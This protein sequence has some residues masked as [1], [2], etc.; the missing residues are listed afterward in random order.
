M[1]GGAGNDGEKAAAARQADVGQSTLRRWLR[2]DDN[3]Q[4]KLRQFREL[5]L[6]HAAL[7]LQQGVATAVCIMYDLIESGK[8]IDPGRVSLIRIAIEF[9]FRAAVYC[10]ILDR[11]KALEKAQ[12]QSQPPAPARLIRQP[13]NRSRARQQ[14]VSASSRSASVGRQALP[15]LG[16]KHFQCGRQALRKAPAAK[17]EFSETCSDL[18]TPRF[19]RNKGGAW[20]RRAAP[21]LRR[22]VRGSRFQWPPSGIRKCYRQTAFLTV[23]FGCQVVKN[24]G[25]PS[26][27][28]SSDPGSDIKNTRFRTKKGQIAR[29]S[30]IGAETLWS[31]AT[32]NKNTIRRHQ[33][34]EAKNGV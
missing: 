23:C 9:A 22:V 12:R 20:L 21:R 6:S 3:F 28:A 15:V 17:R 19:P 7:M 32:E 18:L 31:Q 1:R 5:A 29:E 2:E 16:D 8:P 4:E 13:Q 11:V 30:D 24:A 27:R 26:A 14:A 34:R 33:L 25:E 10:D